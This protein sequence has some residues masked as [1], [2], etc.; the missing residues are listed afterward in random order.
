MRGAGRPITHPELA[1]IMS[2]S[3]RAS[4]LTSRFLPCVELP[5][6]VATF[7]NPGLCITTRS[8]QSLGTVDCPLSNGERPLATNRRYRPA[9]AN[10]P[11]RPVLR[12]RRDRRSGTKTLRR[13]PSMP[14]HV[15]LAIPARSPRR[16]TNTASGRPGKAAREGLL[17]Q[18]LPAFRNHTRSAP[19][20]RFPVPLAGRL[21]PHRLPPPLRRGFRWDLTGPRGKGILRRRRLDFLSFH[22]IREKCLIAEKSPDSANNHRAYQPYLCSAIQFG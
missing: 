12:Q 7:H 4:C 2:S 22:R 18:S 9:R 20:I 8:G 5:S 19:R 16:S 11:S 3:P 13:M 10:R 6:A 1:Q 15:P 14:R 21:R 17:A